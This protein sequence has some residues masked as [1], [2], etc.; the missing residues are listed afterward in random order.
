MEREVGG[1]ARTVLVAV[2]LIVSAGAAAGLVITPEKT[3]LDDYDTKQEF[4]VT[5]LNDGFEPA[6][7]QL[8]PTSTSTYLTPYISIEPRQFVLQP[9]EQ[10]N[11]KVTTNFPSEPPP[12][13]H[14]LEVEAFS[15]SERS[16]KVSFE[17]DGEAQEGLELRNVEVQLTEKG[18][19]M[20]ASV[21]Y[22]NTGNVYLFLTPTLTVNRASDG[23]TVKS[24]EYP[25]P[26]VVAP[27]ESYPLTL[28]QDVGSIS[29]G[30][31][32]ARVGASYHSGEGSE[33]ES[34]ESE[35]YAFEVEPVEE[36]TEPEGTQGVWRVVAISI[37]IVIVAA[38][39]LTSKRKK[40][41][42]KKG[43]EAK[44]QDLSGKGTDEAWITQEVAATRCQVEGLEREAH[45]FA[46]EAH[47]WLR[48]R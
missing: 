40:K 3:E 2:I 39:R 22:R 45:D 8:T 38:W 42:A 1:A 48:R 25:R 33:E 21:E 34:L 44:T 37:G 14:V 10:M 13:R 5:F 15:G 29:E 43:R 35:L 19:A 32:A 36:A 16:F 46:N 31:Y 24:L 30:D 47:A 28:R 12:Q 20:T 18:H 6:G 26:L 41:R 27:G 23:A 9:G 4:I 7:C 17:P 11:V